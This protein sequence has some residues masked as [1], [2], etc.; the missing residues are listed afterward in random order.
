[1]NPRAA[2]IAGLFASA[3]A[4]ASCG[5]SVNGIPATPV[6][7]TGPSSLSELL[8][9]RLSG[10][11][12]GELTLIDIKGGTGAAKTAG[13][14]ECVGAAFDKV[15]SEKNVNTLSIT[16]SGS[17]LT[18][19]LV[20]AG[21]GLACEYTGRVGSGSTFVL[22]AAK[23]TEDLNLLCSTGE[24]RKLQLVGSSLTASFNDPINP[25]S[26]SGTAAHTYNV[27][28][29]EEPLGAMVANH[30]FSGLTRR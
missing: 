2:L 11:W 26:I 13:A 28:D 14:L 22:H 29:P 16:Q 19:K 8:L 30:S 5:D 24:T 7:P 20:S 25:T 1:M 27:Y 21:T 9:P 17:D 3:M 18:A 12:G 15:I 4:T 10:N 23:C 6:A